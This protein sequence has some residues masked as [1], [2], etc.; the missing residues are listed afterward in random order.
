M[1]S[2]YFKIDGSGINSYTGLVDINLKYYPAVINPKET[3][4]YARAGSSSNFIALATSYDSTKNELTFTT[5]TLGD[6]AFGIPQIVDSSYSPIPIE[7]LDEKVVNV[8]DTVQLMW[9]TRGIV[10]G[11]SLQV[12]SDSLFTNLVIDQTLSS[13]SYQIDNLNNNSQ[14]YWRVRATNSAG[15]SEWSDPSSFITSSPFI[16]VSY[17]N[18]S[19]TLYA[20]STYIVRWNDNLQDMV[21]IDL[22]KDGAVTS[23]I[24]DSLLSETNAYKWE[25][26]SSIGEDSTYKIKITDINDG[27]LSDLSDNTFS[28]KGG[29]VGVNENNN[30]VKEYKL[31]QN[32]P[33]PFNPSTVIEYAL[34]AQSNVTISVFN[35]IG[36]RVSVLFNGTE[37]AGNH[38]VIWNAQNLSSGVYFYKIE[39]VGINKNNSFTSFKKAILIK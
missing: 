27:N 30:F 35:I 8:E 7:P 26:P 32:Y 33:N 9:G 37:S 38:S 25:V 20:D 3:I 2:N 29:V 16:N 17:P 5:T 13:T 14:Y 34:P 36:Q 24:A 1:V 15:E 31:F 10:T 12:S 11:Y 4:V 6:F 18:G 22:I 21:R 39:A 19:D 28:I 23:I